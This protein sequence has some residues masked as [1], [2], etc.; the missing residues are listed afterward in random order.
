MSWSN[1]EIDEHVEVQRTKIL[2]LSVT[3]EFFTFAITINRVD[4]TFP[5]F[6]VTDYPI[7]PL[8]VLLTV[9]NFLC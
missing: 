3:R 7:Y 2:R 9:L 5:A 1:F 4:Y 6:F 8:H